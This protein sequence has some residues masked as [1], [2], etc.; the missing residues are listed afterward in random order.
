MTRH[1]KTMT[2]VRG[3][4]TAE[5][6][7]VRE[8]KHELERLTDLALSRGGPTI[9]NRFGW[10]IVIAAEPSGWTST[11]FKPEDLAHGAQRWMT[12]SHRP[13]ADRMDVLAATRLHAAQAAWT[14]ETNDAEHEA[15]AG[16]SKTGADDFRRWAAFQRRYSAE[17]ASGATDAEAWNR[18]MD[19]R[20]FE[21]AA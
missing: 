7:T 17:K 6:P 4:L 20:R 21:A 12:T 15:A 10:I 18:A 9:E 14:P 8:A 3:L 16:L 13:E 2:A 1:R 5:A 11:M 19:A